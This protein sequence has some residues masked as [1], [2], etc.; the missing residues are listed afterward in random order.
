MIEAAAPADVERWRAWAVCAHLAG[1]LIFA[2]VPFGGLIATIVI[3]SI[4]HNDGSYIRENAR[5]ALN[6]QI[7]LAIFDFVCLG[8]FFVAWLW[9]IFG[10]A[11]APP[12]HGQVQPPPPQLFLAL[13][14]AVIA[15][16][17]NL[18]AIVNNVVAAVAASNGKVGRYVAAI[19]FVRA[20]A[21]STI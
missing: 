7:T 11:T 13:G 16:F 4:R 2:S 1:L 6:M 17:V 19:E 8:A 10:F 14:V 9:M 12:H 20:P 5:S 15:I 3:Y 21:R 18:A